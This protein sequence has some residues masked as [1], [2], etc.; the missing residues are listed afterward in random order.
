MYQLE[1]KIWFW[2]LGIIPVIWLFFLVLQF[3]KYKAQN[4]F[5]DKEL[6]KRLSP[7]K[8]I[9]KSILKMVVLTME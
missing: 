5:A 3:W 2:V 6:L 4:K 9:F 1:E 7:N 8:S